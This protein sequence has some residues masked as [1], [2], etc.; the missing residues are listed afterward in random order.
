[1]EH[2]GID[3]HLKSSEVHLL[4]EAGVLSERARIPTTERSLRRWFGGRERM[5]ICIG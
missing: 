3:L 1:V 2:C 4:D 5:Q